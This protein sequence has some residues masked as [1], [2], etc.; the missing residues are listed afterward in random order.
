MSTFLELCQAVARDSGTVS[1]LTA[2]STVIG[3]TGR[4]LRIVNWTAEGYRDIQRRRDDWRWLRREFSGQTIATVSRYALN[5]TSERFK[6]WVFHSD[7]GEDT[8]SV[9]LTSAG[10]TGEGWLRY[11]PWDDFRRTRLFGS[12]A[13]DTG[14]PRDITVDPLNRLVVHPIPD[15]IYTIRGEYYQAP[16]ILTADADVPEMP[17]AHHE[18]IK[19]QA[20]ILLGTFDEAK[21]QIPAWV[22]FLNRHIAS[23]ERTQTPRVVLAGPLA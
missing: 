22:A 6:H 2:P 8:F 3:Q 9:Y 21:E 11:V 13:A 20:L 14:K 7:S 12:A 4:L 15:D 18:A 1:D 10:Q 16:Q 23:L 5:T 19:W 17:E